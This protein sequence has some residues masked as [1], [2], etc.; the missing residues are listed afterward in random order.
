MVYVVKIPFML[1][2]SGR[3]HDTLREVGPEVRTLRLSGELEGTT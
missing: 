1:I 2:S 3:F